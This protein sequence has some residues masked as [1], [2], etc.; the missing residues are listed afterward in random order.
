MASQKGVIRQREHGW[1][2]SLQP[3]R[4][5]APLADQAWPS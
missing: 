5:S 1:G 2:S 4:M 3:A